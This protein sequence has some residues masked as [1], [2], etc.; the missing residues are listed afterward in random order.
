MAVDVLSEIVIA[1]PREAVAAFTC[2]PS[3]APAWYANI[4]S[5]RWLTEPPVAVGSRMDFVARFLGRTLAYTYHVRELVTDQ[6]LVMS[7]EQGP[8]SMETTYEFAD[9]DLGCTI[10][11]LRNRGEPAGFSRVVGPLMAHA[12]GRAN[13]KDLRALKQLL[14]S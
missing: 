11:T 1:R 6:R 10:I 7:T 5:I 9:A 14:E 4:E 13:R 3:N 12:V 2:D 8:F